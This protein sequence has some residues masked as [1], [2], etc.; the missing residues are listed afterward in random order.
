LRYLKKPKPM[1][2]KPSA[3]EAK[4]RQQIADE[5]GIHYLTLMRR[6]KAVGIELPHGVVLPKHQK[7]IYEKLGYPPDVP[8]IFLNDV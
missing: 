5:Y 7:E 1:R 6:L 3:L 8:K 4:T 2:K